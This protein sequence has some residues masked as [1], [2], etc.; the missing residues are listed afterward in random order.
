MTQELELVTDQQG[1]GAPV[2]QQ[3]KTTGSTPADLI[4]YAMESGADLDRLERLMQMQIEWDKREAEKAFHDAMAT[5][6]L[7]APDLNKV[8]GA[9]FSAKGGTTSYAYSSIGDINPEII[10]WLAEYG[11]N[12]SWEPDQKGATLGITCVL[13]HKQGFSKRYRLEAGHDTTGSKNSIQALGSAQTY[14]ERYTLLGVTG[15][16]IK[17][18][19]DDDGYSAQDAPEPTVAKPII[20]AARF[21]TALA[22]VRAKEYPAAN[23]RKNFELSVDQETALSDAEKEAAQ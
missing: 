4:R 2:V 13:T 17:D 9:S 11:F 8:Q 10:K 14:L 1:R 12:S 6:K 5:A 23:V 15:L 7:T 19:R 20:N 16:S 18:G 22:K 3:H 21:A